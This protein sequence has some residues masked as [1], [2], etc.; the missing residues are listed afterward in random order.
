VPPD[1]PKHVDH[2]IHWQLVEWGNWLRGEMVAAG[3]PLLKSPGWAR[4]IVNP[5]DSIEID[6][7]DEDACAKTHRGMLELIMQDNDSATVLTHYYRDHWTIDAK[8][9][10]KC[11]AQFWRTGG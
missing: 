2:R 5:G 6:F 4:Q 7:C 1:L 10:R 11:R 8:T 9:L 3:I